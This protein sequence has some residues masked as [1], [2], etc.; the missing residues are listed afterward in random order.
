MLFWEWYC[1]PSDDIILFHVNVTRNWFSTRYDAKHLLFHNI[2]QL[3]KYETIFNAYSLSCTRYINRGRQ[4][5]SNNFDEK[6]SALDNLSM[7]KHQLK[8]GQNRLECS[9]IADTLES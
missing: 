1:L 2:V 4:K 3:R 7:R 5:F 6:N 8:I 9:Q